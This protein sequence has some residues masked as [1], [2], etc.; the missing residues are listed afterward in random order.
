MKRTLITIV[1]VISLLLIPLQSF[2]AK[3][4]DKGPGGKAYDNASDNASFNWDKDKK[5]DKDKCPCESV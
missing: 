1:T 3:S 4:G 5:K 2:A